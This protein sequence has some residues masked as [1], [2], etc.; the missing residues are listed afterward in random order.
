M[1]HE[2]EDP[3]LHRKFEAVRDQ[4]KAM[5]PA[6][7]DVWQGSLRLSRNPRRPRL[8]I[9]A[10]AAAVVVLTAAIVVF[11]WNRSP[12]PVDSGIEVQLSEWR[13]STDFLL[14]TPG[15]DLLNRIPEVP[16]FSSHQI[17]QSLSQ[18]RRE[19]TP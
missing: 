19:K 6:F 18:N 11:W 7:E 13:A 16:S 4:D 14:K 3:D 10:F 15:S 5:T 12:R 9:R 17:L 2:W 1:T 8:I